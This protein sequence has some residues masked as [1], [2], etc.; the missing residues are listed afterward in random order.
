MN[1]P[2]NPALVG[3][4]VL[5]ALAIALAALLFFGSDRMVGK[6]QWF[7]SFFRSDTSGLDIGAPVVLRGVKIGQV[8]D[9]K[10]GYQLDAGEF[11]VRVEFV[12]DESSVEW[13]SAIQSRGPAAGDAFYREL[14]Q[15]G[16]RTRLVMQSLVTGKLMLEVGFFPSSVL[17]MRGVDREIPAIPTALEKLMDNL[18]SINLVEMAQRLEAVVAGIDQLINSEEMPQIRRELLALLSEH[19]TLAQ[20]LR[21]DWP[22]LVGEMQGS[23]REVRRL[24]ENSEQSVQNIGQVARHLDAQLAPTGEQLRATLASIDLSFKAAQRT[25]GHADRLIADNS[26]LR[27][28]LLATLKDLSAAAKSLESFADYLERHPESLLKGKR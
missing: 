27:N 10:V 23:L 24:A 25:L 14:I 7:V 17:R 4:F 3:G 19:R 13:P 20:Q 18:R 21:N 26:P 1:R 15:R 22:G 6:R 8:T 16:L 2:L 11:D 9:I 28:E 12:V 5:G